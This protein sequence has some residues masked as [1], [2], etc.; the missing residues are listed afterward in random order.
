VV[1]V[2]VTIEKAYSVPTK[3]VEEVIKVEDQ[4]SIVK[5]PVEHQ[6]PI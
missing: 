1:Q 5:V 2:P 4:V 6:T 3:V